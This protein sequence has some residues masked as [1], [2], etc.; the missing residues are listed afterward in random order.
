MTGMG[1]NSIIQSFVVGFI[2]C[3]TVIFIL[4]LIIYFNVVSFIMLIDIK[5]DL[6]LMSR[7]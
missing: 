6:Q 1:I 5:K 4:L 7:R 3:V 2:E